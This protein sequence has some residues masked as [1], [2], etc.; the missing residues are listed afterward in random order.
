MPRCM[1]CSTSLSLPLSHTLLQMASL[2]LSLSPSFSLPLSLSPSLCFS[3]GEVGIGDGILSDGK[4]SPGRWMHVPSPGRTPL[5][6]PR[7][8]KGTVG[9][10]ALH[11]T[12]HLLNPTHTQ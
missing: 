7:D 4:Q 2:S 12:P 6:G 9:S 5:I 1:L 8:G 11:C 3:L 10:T